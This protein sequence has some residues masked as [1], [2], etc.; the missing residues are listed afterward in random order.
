MAREIQI[1]EE[2]GLEDYEVYPH[3]SA[4]ALGL[5]AEAT[6][7]VPHIG[8][9]TIWMV[10]STEQGGGVAEMLPKMV[11]L[12]REVGLD[13]RWLVIE[14]DE[15]EF[16]ALTKRLHNLIHGEG[17]PLGNSE[18]REIYEKVS[19]E[20]ADAIGRLVRDGDVLV[21]HDPQPLGAG[22]MLLRERPLIGIWRCHIG[23]DERN[24]ATSSAWKFLKP[25]LDGYVEAVFSAPEYI[26]SYL[27]Q[28]STV[29]HPGIDP[30]SH[31][32]RDLPPHKLQGILCNSALAVEHEPVLM[33]PFDHPAKRLSK[34][35]EWVPAVS[36][37]EIGLLFRPIVTQISRWDRLKGFLPLLDAFVALK[38]RR[39]TP[40]PDPL[41][42]RRLELARLV[43]AGPDP[44][45]ISDD[46]EGLEVI[47]EL[48]ESFLALDPEIQ[49]DVV[50]LT[51]PMASRKENALMCNA[52]QR[53]SSVVVQNSVQE[54]FG[55]TV[56]EAMWKRR[57]VVG[58]QAC[59]IRQQ[60]REG[61][62]GHL[63]PDPFDSF[64]LAQVLDE[65]LADPFAR[66]YLASQAQKRVH[67]EFLVFSQ[68]KRWLRLIV[69]TVTRPSS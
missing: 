55:L 12:L 4:A 56:T 30:L 13:V 44:S 68:L 29:I 54:G 61:I 22:A 9:R 27:V 16:F 5:R 3:L 63:V 66:E 6:K 17:E 1:D 40:S 49:N 31:K 48:A 50:L 18:S 10:N 2:L 21:I 24:E 32:N 47:T 39:D 28:H 57:P 19:R 53:C 25:W 37:G 42:H 38:E 58:T 41:H 33:P 7:M 46:P 15:P 34:T 20:N 35:G 69:D 62:D 11:S 14:S 43:L 64:R 67:D 23:L 52:L 45:S 60:I 59:G 51:L 65:L 36:E 26:P 8:E